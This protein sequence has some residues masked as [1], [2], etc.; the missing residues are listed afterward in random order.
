VIP[1]VTPEEMRAIDASSAV[2]VDVLIGRAGAA[3]ARAAVE[4]LDGSYGRRVV[5]IAGK[6]NNGADGRDAARRLRARGAHVDV[7]DAAALPAVL[8][9]CDLVI[10]AAYGTGFRSAGRETSWT[11]P[12]V[13]G[14]VPVLAVDIPSGVDGGTGRAEG[15][16]LF[17]D[18]TVTFAALKPGLLFA[19]GAD[20]AGEVE[21]IDIGLD[22]STAT[23]WLVTDDDIVDWL[24]ERAN[25]AHKYHSAAWVI[26]GSPGMTGAARLAASAAQRA[27]AGYVRLST[28]G[29]DADAPME[30]VR[31]P[32]PAEGWSA[33][34]L[35]DL[36]RFKAV[37]I[38][39]GLGRRSDDD[40][41]TLAR[42]CP[43]PIVIDG[44]GLTA[45]GLDLDG[46]VAHA[47]LTPHDGEY[48]R[49]MGAR[50]GDDRIDAA[51]RLA[52]RA[53]ATVVL[54]GEAMVVAAPDSEV[55][56]A[57]EGDARLATAGSG[58]VLTGIIVALL[59]QGMEPQLAAASAAFLLGA[60]ADL[61]WRRGLVAGD[62]VALLPVV[63]E[64]LTS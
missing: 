18:R 44:D 33:T 9:R 52:E 63:L 41:R 2:H 7:L 25:D 37:A 35:G 22:A 47:V 4:L 38:G 58:D 34:V 57:A 49:L 13:P 54:K 59:A 30:V 40:V 11:P 51:R 20:H 31:T 45:L 15:H 32:L 16:A 27:G 61:G 24:P 39:P 36:D 26:A 48:E 3:V 56:V 12:D 46:L 53:G 17:A 21:V 42:Q 64:G 10:D 50:P 6:G 29:G 62:V 5:V 43:V 28:P 19:D 60:A 14:D 55:L 8:P 23:A 1:I